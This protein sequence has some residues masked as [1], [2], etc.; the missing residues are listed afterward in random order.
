MRGFLTLLGKEWRDARALAIAMS[1]LAAGVPALLRFALAGTTYTDKIEPMLVP[2]LVGL[3]G[4]AIASDLVATE[5]ATRDIDALALLP[6][7]LAHVWAAKVTF[8]L[9]A[10]AVLFVW[11]VECLVLGAALVDGPAAALALVDELP[12]LLLPSLL[13]LPALAGTLFATSVIDRSFPAFVAGILLAAGLG[14]ALAGLQ[15][16]IGQK[17]DWTIV[18][19]VC[20]CLVG[21][22]WIAFAK[23]GAHR[24]R[25]RRVAFGVG[26]L[27]V[28]LVPPPAAYGAW[29]RWSYMALEPG[30][31]EAMIYTMCVSP[32]ERWLAMEVGKR[33]RSR[34][35][36]V[37]T[38]EIA[39]GRVHE[40]TDPIAVLRPPVWADDAR[41]V[42]ETMG[43]RRAIDPAT[44]DDRGVVE[45]QQPALWA[46]ARRKGKV[47]ASL[48]EY[49]ISSRDPRFDKITVTSA[50]DPLLP[51]AAPGVAYL[52]RGKGQV[53]RRDLSTGEERT[54]VDAGSVP[55]WLWM[56]PRGR[57]MTLQ[58]DGQYVVLDARDGRRVAGP[59]PKPRHWIGSGSDRYMF[60][61]EEIAPRRWRM[62]LLD[63]E[64]DT[65]IDVGEWPEQWPQYPHVCELSG[66]RL[67]L[68]RNGNDIDL[69]DTSGRVLRRVYETRR[70]GE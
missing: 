43:G 30:D 6:V 63:L 55:Q 29:W 68:L 60:D 24:S 28:L 42:V 27:L 59:G 22:S 20:A 54:I 52:R 18:A 45:D 64:R 10:V 14:A 65:R 40:V 9:A 3:F 53:V 34:A 23:G 13:V 31:P 33:D 70:E 58:V 26:G 7:A 46:W 5:V 39:S 50:S 67:L 36:R 4:C 19:A 16:L 62:Y 2:V 56:S 1:V 61:S 69:M 17:P 37:W 38:L 15:S 41:L 48:F 47:D 12:K 8:L 66:E 32:D 35:L 11:T 44:G 25:L 57:Y 49:E 21:A 51:G